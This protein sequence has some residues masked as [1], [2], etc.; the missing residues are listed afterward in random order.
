MLKG[1]SVASSMQVFPNFDVECKKTPSE[2]PVAP[3]SKEEK[4]ID[5]SSGAKEVQSS[6][7][8][9]RGEEEEE[10]DIS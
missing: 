8:P 4:I 5:I 10:E 6:H 9:A 1:G 7:D 3:I 2:S